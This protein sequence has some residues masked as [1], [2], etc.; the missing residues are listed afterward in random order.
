[1]A[2]FS[3]K[4]KNTIITG[5]SSGIGRELALCF[6]EA[7]ARLYLGSHPSEVESLAGLADLIGKKY[8][9]APGIFSVDLTSESGPEQF[10]SSVKK[11]A[12]GIDILVNNAGI[13]AYGEFG[14]LTLTKQ[15]MILKLNVLAYMK[16]MHLALPDIIAAKGRILNVVSVSAFQPAVYQAVYG[17]SK[18][19]IQSL[20]EAVSEELRG[21]GVKI[22]TLNP[23]Y[24][25]TPLLHSSGF[26]E[27]V[28]WFKMAGMARPDEVARKGFKAFIKGKEVYIPGLKHHILHR[29][30]N[31]ILPRS[32]VN[33]FSRL[34]CAKI[35]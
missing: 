23:P 2:I 3:V 30:L 1:M 24:T 35:N 32:L 28:R 34:A 13:M 9:S 12:T 19:F 15:E 20:S 33:R 22:C 7:G 26:P 29:M 6:A 18:A 14:N 4:E 21:P 17:A 25:E 10:F 27:K 8:G 11:S 5:A 31:S 16:L